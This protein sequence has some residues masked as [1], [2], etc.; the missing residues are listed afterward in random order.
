MFTQAKLHAIRIGLKIV[1]MRGFSDLDIESD[2]LTT[3]N[4]IKS[5]CLPEH[6]CHCLVDQ[7]KDM[8]TCLAISSWKHVFRKTNQVADALAK[9]GLSI[10]N[11]CIFD[12]NPS[13]ITLKVI[14]DVAST[15]FFRGF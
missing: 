3:I 15:T 9:Y 5:G 12:V 1:A 14:A 13:F 4:L 2:S 10:D 7:I 6:P 8:A 11:G